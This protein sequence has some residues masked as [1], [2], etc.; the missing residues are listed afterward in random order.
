MI[1]KPA[2]DGA[3]DSSDDFPSAEAT[4]ALVR[5][6]SLEIQWL[7][8][9][10][11]KDKAGGSLPQS[12][13]NW[14]QSAESASAIV[15][16]SWFIFHYFCGALVIALL[17]YMLFSN[18]AT[19]GW[20]VLG[21]NVINLGAIALPHYAGIRVRRQFAMYLADNA[22]LVCPDCGY[23]LHG[24]PHEHQCPEC[25]RA[26]SIASVRTY[27]LRWMA[28]RKPGDYSTNEATR[29]K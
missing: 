20:L 15:L 3:D 10:A 29:G 14:F 16:K 8:Q 18:F 1:K 11:W 6:N 23:L 19:S 5:R 27:W 13:W 24:L 28:A 22:G 4:K 25:G 17:V 9:S 2:N 7:R 21:V 26:Y 12:L